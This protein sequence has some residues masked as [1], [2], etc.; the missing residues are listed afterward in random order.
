MKRTANREFGSAEALIK[1]YIPGYPGRRRGREPSSAIRAG[2][3]LALRLL[4][5]HLGMDEHR[6]NARTRRT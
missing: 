6:P 4:G 5:D 1:F 2:Q 3:E